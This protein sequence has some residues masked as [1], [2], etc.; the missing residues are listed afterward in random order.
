MTSISLIGKAGAGKSAIAEKLCDKGYTRLSFASKVKDIAWDI[1]QKPLDKTQP[2]DREFLQHLGTD[3]ARAYD[4]DVWVK[5]FRIAYHKWLKYGRKD[6]VVDDARFLNEIEFLKSEG[7]VVVRVVGR[8]YSMGALGNH[9]SET[10]LDTYKADFEVD[11][12]GSLQ[13]TMW[14]L[15]H[16]IK[17]V[18]SAK[19]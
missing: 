19:K 18:E 4:P 16:I 3:L 9:V 10:Q 11:N 17:T 1:L 8:G 2:K 15:Q 7:F 6:F 14:Q 5:H 12:S 13:E